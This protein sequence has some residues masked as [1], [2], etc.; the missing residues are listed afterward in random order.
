[1]N[2]SDLTKFMCNGVASKIDSPALWT[3]LERLRADWSMN[4]SDLTKFMCGGVASKIDS[5]A[6]W[7]G[8]ERLKQSLG[9]TMVCSMM[10]NSLASRIARI[11]P[12]GTVFVDAVLA[13]SVALKD[14]NRAN[15]I[16][17]FMRTPYISSPDTLRGLHA[18]IEAAV[19]S[20]GLDQYVKEFS[21]R[22]LGWKRQRA[23]EL[24]AAFRG[25]SV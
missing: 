7:T 9:T 20:A 12:E 17:R 21:G 6:L 25:P 11:G 16:K 15:Y 13:V 1:M 23:H 24:A 14:A 2:K 8:L 3:G 5:P 10:N 22:S 4:K 18:D 19:A